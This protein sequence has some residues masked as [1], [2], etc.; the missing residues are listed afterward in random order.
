[1]SEISKYED[2]KKKLEGLCDEHH[3]TYRFKKEAY[4]ITLSLRPVQGMYEQLSLLENA[5][6]GK[7]RISPDAVM[8]FEKKDGDILIQTFGAFAMSEGLQSKFKNLFKK[9]CDFWM[10][11]FFRAVIENDSL[12]KG[13][14][15]VINEDEA[16]DA[17]PSPEEDPDD[18]EEA[19]LAEDEQGEDDGTP[20]EEL[21][22]AATQLVR[23]ENKCTVAML[24]R[25]LKLGYSKATRLVELLEE[26]GIVGPYRGSEPREV[27]PFD[28][29]EAPEEE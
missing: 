19:E 2:Q 15:P 23:M 3:L 16:D 17:E 13:M 12:K 5:E 1:M 28:E 20:D 7:G 8:T 6:D 25:R 29:P 22:T 10:Q 21:I 27:L 26:R 14:M 18:Y 9:L 4:P 24:Q 11:Y